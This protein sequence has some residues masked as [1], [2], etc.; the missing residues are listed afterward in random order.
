MRPVAHLAEEAYF[1]EP[2][3]SLPF[4]YCKQQSEYLARNKGL[5]YEKHFPSAEGANK[6]SLITEWNKT[7]KQ[8]R[9]TA[10]HTLMKGCVNIEIM[11]WNLPVL[12]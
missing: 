11:G 7:I 3:I 6:C 9:L 2:R 8:T 10:L 4:D 12:C 5:K 1:D